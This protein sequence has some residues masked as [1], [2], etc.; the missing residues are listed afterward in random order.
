[1][2]RL[3]K[4]GFHSGTLP[5]LFAKLRRAERQACHSRAW[6]S[7][8]RLRAA[9]HHVEESVRHFAKREL[10]AFLNGSRRWTAGPVQVAAVEAGS[11]RIRL[12]LACP[13]LGDDALALKFEEQSGWLLAHV[14]RPGWL[15]R[16]TA[17]QTAVFALALTGF[18]KKAGVDLVREQIEA[19]FA[20]ACPP[21][22][23]TD[24]GLVVW[25][26]GRL[27][28]EVVYDL[29]ERPLLHPCVVAGW[30][31]D[32]LPVLEAGQLLFRERAVLWTDWVAVWE[33]DES[34]AGPPDALVPGVGLLPVVD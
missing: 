15:S 2:L 13:A 31:P 3:L 1:V 4:P 16:V 22:D 33:R 32:G 27:E 18:Y 30:P 9:L 34:G 23:I 11:N 24:E 28:V 14:A 20:P 8:R 6:R 10:L 29:H 12:E 21:Y 25:P 19:S 7:A 17:Q 5:K 26:G